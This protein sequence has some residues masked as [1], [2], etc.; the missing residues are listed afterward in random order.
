MAYLVGASS[1]NEPAVRP[2]LALNPFVALLS[3]PEGI[4]ASLQQ[5]LPFQYRA[6]MEFSTHDWLGV[7]LRYPRWVNSLAVYLLGTIILAL[8]TVFAI[9]PC[10][11]WRTRSER[12]RG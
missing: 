9:D 10:H 5:L 2:L 3:V 8:A 7:S 6:A 4:T 1:Q 12:G 11:R